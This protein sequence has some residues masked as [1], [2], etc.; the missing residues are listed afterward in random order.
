MQ[1]VISR[2]IISDN[3]IGNI[4][5]ANYQ[6]DKSYLVSKIDLWKYI[7]KYRCS[8]QAGESILV[9]IQALNATYFAI[10]FAAAELSLKIIIIDYNRDD[11]FND[12]TFYDPKTKL[13][14]PIDIF[15]HDATPETYE[16]S[17]KF[18]FF[19]SCSNRSY[20]VLSDIDM[21]ID[22]DEDFET[23]KN[24]F[25]NPSD[26]L[27]R[28]TSSGTTGTPKIVE[29]SHEFL[30]KVSIRNSI[31][32]SGQCL[33]S[34][35][36][37]HGS[38]LAVYLLPVFASPAV[39]ENLFLESPTMFNPEKIVYFLT[40]LEKF[41]DTLEYIIFPYPS[42]INDFIDVSKKRNIIWPKLNVQTL[43]YIQDQAKAGIV[44]GIFKSI[45]SIFGS[46]ETSGPVFLAQ[47]EK[48]T[49]GRRS[50]WFKKVDDFYE[51]RLD[52]KQM[53]H[54]TMPVYNTEIVTNDRFKKDSKFYQHVGRSDIA[55]ING[56]IFDLQLING[57]NSKNPQANILL[58]SIKNSI[59][60]IFWNSKDE[61]LESY[62]VNF[63]KHM[64]N[65]AKIDKTAI[66]DRSSFESGVKIDNELLRE[67]FRNH[68]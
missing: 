11:H 7:L 25:P 54:V 4:L 9:G 19:S 12:T 16:A 35:N 48:G 51:I 31:R 63:F 6:F 26:I 23:V 3:F 1:N 29:H 28:C 30:H 5:S 22:N 39:T 44:E 18:K 41:A 42:H 53:L 10:I 58:D 2:H 46:N 27:M 43:S 13:L 60:L 45:T 17:T 55:K 62:Y 47:I 37:N 40:I 52:S 36:L 59:Y 21:S 64:F 65:G 38:S 14:S 66:L 24:I 32:F 15:L 67:Y 33:H 56:N 34:R 61:Q 68:V 49:I 8:A 57:L 20:C 50:N